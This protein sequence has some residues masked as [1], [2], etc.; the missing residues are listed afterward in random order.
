MQGDG[1]V[2]FFSNTIDQ[3]LWQSL[4]TLQGQEIVSGF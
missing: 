4:A 3:V 2:K 1:S